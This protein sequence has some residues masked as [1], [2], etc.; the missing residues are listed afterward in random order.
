[1]KKILY[2]LMIIL[3][4]FSMVNCSSSQAPE[5]TGENGEVDYSDAFLLDVRTPLEYKNG[6]VDGSVNIPLSELEGNTDEIPK[7]KLI[8]VYCVSGTRSKNAIKI[9]ENEGFTNLKN[10]ISSSNVRQLLNKE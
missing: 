9:L 6:S 1:M 5:E 3:I 4:Q 10:G 8:L 2:V 7:D